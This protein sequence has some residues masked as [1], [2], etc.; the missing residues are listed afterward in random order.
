MDPFPSGANSCALPFQDYVLSALFHPCL[1]AVPLEP[2]CCRC[3]YVGSV[4]AL[5]WFMVFLL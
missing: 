2:L 3:K 1:L 5:L 4:E